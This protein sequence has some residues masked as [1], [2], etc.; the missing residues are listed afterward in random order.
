ME[1]AQDNAGRSKSLAITGV[2]LA[3]GLPI[4]MLLIGRLGV[5]DGISLFRESLWWALALIFLFWAIKVE[6]I[7]LAALGFKRP[8]WGTLG[9]GLLANLVLTFLIGGC[10]ALL[11][12]ALGIKTDPKALGV[13]ASQPVWM[14]FLL[15]LRAGFVEELLFRF[16]PITRLHWL[17]GNKWIASMIPGVIFIGM[18]APSWGLAHLI[19]VSLAALVLTLL[20][21]KRRDFWCSAFA[22]FLADFIPFAMAAMA[23]GH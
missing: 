7:T 23:M 10:Y 22:H 16:Y 3:L 4:A 14:I 19:P 20:Y 1:P 13:I 21:W 9:W 12:P 15:T 8:T 11:F 17:T 5:A 6:K 18:H 2:V